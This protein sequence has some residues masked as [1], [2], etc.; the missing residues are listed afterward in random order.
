[1]DQAYNVNDDGRRLGVR[2]KPE[3]NKMNTRRFVN[4]AAG[5]AIAALTMAA[6]PAPGQSLADLMSYDGLKKVD[7]KGLDLA[8]VRPGATLAGYNKV[9]IA[10]VTVAFHKGWDPK[11]PGGGSRRLGTKD[12][13]RIRDGVA[14]I[15]Y[16][17]FAKALEDKGGYPVVT[18]PGPDVLSVKPNIINLY[19][20]AP[21]VMT[22]GRS[23][24]YTVSA[25]EMTLFAELSD[26]ETGEVIARVIDRSQARDTGSMQWSNSVT[27]TAEARRM[28]AQWAGMLRRA[29]DTARTAG[30]PGNH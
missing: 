24:T 4:V 29:L 7:I 2:K 11:M 28:A 13:E 14:S 1:M 16:Q 30:A 15:V 5:L 12:I 27:N 25:G 20:S 10:P 6:H 26:S 23:R 19:V 17:E 22:A 8:Y 3:R 18:T 9:Q 21:D